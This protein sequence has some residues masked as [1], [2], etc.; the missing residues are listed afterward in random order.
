MPDLSRT[1]PQY[2]KI[3]KQEKE[4]VQYFF[5][6]TTMALVKSL[7]S[8]VETKFLNLKNILSRI[9]EKKKAEQKNTNENP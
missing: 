3:K 1:F 6:K 2:F 4:G 7:K 5:K 9:M 8:L